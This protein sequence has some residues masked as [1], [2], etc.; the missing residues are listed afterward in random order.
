MDLNITIRDADLNDA[1]ALALLATQLG[2]PCNGS[3][4]IGRIDPYLDNPEARIIVAVRN[5]TVVG[6]LS[7][8]TIQHFYTKPFMEI[9]GFVVDE[10]ERRKG[11]G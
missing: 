8:N 10:R 4:I 5:G 7:L 9:S 6:W 11:I 2:Y 1:E 3:E